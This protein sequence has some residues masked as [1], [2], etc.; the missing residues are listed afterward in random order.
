[1]H[2]TPR[3][4]NLPA[5]RLKPPAR[6]PMTTVV[7]VAI[8]VPGG[9]LPLHVKGLGAAVVASLLHQVAACVDLPGGPGCWDLHCRG[10][11]LG[12]ATPLEDIPDPLHLTLAPAA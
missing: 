10:V 6:R 9:G 4:R 1:M 11:P 3:R 12:L 8:R 2:R 7:E 5:T